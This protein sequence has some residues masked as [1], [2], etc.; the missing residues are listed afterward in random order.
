M[1]LTR[2]TFLEAAVSIPLMNISTAAP[3]VTV[4]GAGAFGSWTAL[5]LQR[6]GACVTLVDAWGPGNTRASSGG[7]TRVIRAI[8]GRDRI[9]VEMVKRS[10][11]LWLQL[12]PSLYVETGAL[13]LHRGDDAYVRS[14]VPIL[15]ELGFPVDSIAVDDARRRWP[16]ISFDGVRSI[17]L[18]RRAGAEQCELFHDL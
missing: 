1:T 7:E 6:L 9:Y 12:D 8:Y 14:S 17:W 10:Y 11:D 16:Q 13:W 18:E 4:V 2:R 15:A 5:H 3:R